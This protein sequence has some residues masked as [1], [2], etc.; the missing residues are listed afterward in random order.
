MRGGA[1]EARTTRCGGGRMV[2]S[3][4]LPSTAADQALGRG[5]APR[6]GVG[7]HGGQRRLEV[8]GDL[9]VVEAGDG[10]VAGQLEAAGERRP[11]CRRWPSGRWRRRSRW[12]APAG[13]AAPWWRRRRPG[14][15]SRTG[16]TAP[17]A[18]SRRAARR[19]RP[20]AGRRRARTSSGPATWAMCRWPSS[21]RCATAAAMPGRSS[22]A[23]HGRLLPTQS[24]PIADRREPDLGEQRGPRVADPQVGEEDAVDPAVRGQPPVAG[25]LAVEVRHDLQEQRL[26][27]R[28]RAPTRCRR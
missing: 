3:A 5:R 18:G 11:T 12:A 4:D 27:E 15:R 2:L 10:Q 25:Q 16:C 28:R 20:R 22:T 23:T 6:V 26:A 17:R 8:G 1:V 24:G 9:G 21:T 19:P 7:A 13:R 14:P